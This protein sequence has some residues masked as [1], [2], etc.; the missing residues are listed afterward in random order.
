[1]ST[2]TA[3][4]RP[5]VARF[6]APAGILLL[7]GIIS[8]YAFRAANTEELS[9][10]LADAQPAVTEPVAA[11]DAGPPLLA[12]GHVRTGARAAAGTD[13]AVFPDLATGFAKLHAGMATSPV[14]VADRDRLIAELDNKHEAETI[15]PVWSATLEQSL[16]TASQAQVMAQAGFNPKDVSTD[17]RSKSC[18]I[19]ARFDNSSEARD[20]AD[21]LLTQMAGSIG[22]ARVAVLPQAD[23]SFEVRVYGVRRS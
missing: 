1:M 13:S 16:E 9:P 3:S 6:A 12:Q 2:H 7:T 15:D 20:W 22:Q 4:A 8:A 17:C 21:R 10:P 14:K 23:G 19:S 11:V 18:R 5:P